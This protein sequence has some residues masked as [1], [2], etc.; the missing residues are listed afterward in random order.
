MMLDQITVRQTEQQVA[1]LREDLVAKDRRIGELSRRVD[2][3][4]ASLRAART[5]PK[6]PVVRAPPS[7]AA[8]IAFASQTVEGSKVVGVKIAPSL[9][10][11]IDAFKEAHN[12]ASARHAVLA[13]LYLATTTLTTTDT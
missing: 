12:I 10:A 13:L 8:A 5:K 2:T 11:E 6:P 1:K 4:D 7:L 9:R 3:L